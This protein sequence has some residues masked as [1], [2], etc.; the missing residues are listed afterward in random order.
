MTAERQPAQVIYE[1]PLSER[2][3]AFLRLEFLLA[4]AR[5]LLPGA[6]RW[7]SRGALEAL[8]DVLV[9]IGRSDL[10]KELLKELDRQ[11]VTLEG[12]ARHPRVDQRRLGE[13]L[14][15][16]RSVLASLRDADSTLGQELR[17]DE[18]LSA[19]RQRSSVPAGTCDFDMPEFHYWL[20][21]PAEQRIEDLTR[22]LSAF[23]DLSEAISLCLELV[24][25]S[26]VQT[27]EVA[28]A[29]FFQKNLDASSPVQMIRVALPPSAGWYPEISAGKHRFTVRFMR[30]GNG[31]SRPAQIEEDAEFDLL[32]CAL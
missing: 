19:V 31:A 18:F 15:R 7:S 25:E 11:A 27:H 14:D 5:H 13:V 23:D 32:C 29:G 17:D 26:A 10:K 1:Q 20:E 28:D 12:L 6:D 30:P 24:R 22:W 2:M 4:R 8:I 3:R 9:V 16:V 21:R